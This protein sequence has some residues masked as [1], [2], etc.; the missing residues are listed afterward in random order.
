MSTN[1]KMFASLPS[2]HL[3]EQRRAVWG[4]MFGFG[5]QEARKKANLSIAEAARLSGM[6]VSEWM[7]IEEGSVPQDINQLRAMTD[8]MAIS[9]DSIANLVL[10]CREA[11]EL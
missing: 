1:L 4:R 9:F 7:A 5:I 10:L 8:A 3:P 2:S 6:Q 11:W